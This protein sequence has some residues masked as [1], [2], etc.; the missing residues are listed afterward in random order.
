[1]TSTR[2]RLAL[3]GA[4]ALLAAGC[5]LISAQVLVSF[6][7]AEHGFDP[8]IVPSPNALAG[9]P[10]DLKTISAY[11]DHKSD[12]KDVDDLAILGTFT[13]LNATPT[14]VELW[15]VAN[16]GSMLTNDAAVRAAG[17]PVWG[18]IHV[19]A[20][21]SAKAGWDASAQ[22]FQNRQ[23]LVGEI[24]GDGR[25]DLYALGTGNYSFRIDKGG[26]IAVIAAGK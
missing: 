6:D 14:D 3:G 16:P 21:G 24:K 1:M 18:P 25:F 2:F 11:N 4:I 26:L 5:V 20:S 13:N 9:V 12:I 8:L 23:A 15:M 22:L 7:F 10:V 17:V 19:P